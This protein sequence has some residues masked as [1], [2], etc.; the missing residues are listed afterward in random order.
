M[1]Q[2][3]L[4]NEIYRTNKI[5]ILQAL[6]CLINFMVT[7]INIMIKKTP[8]AQNGDAMNN[9]FTHYHLQQ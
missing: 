4:V 5:N 7:S 2:K 8:K 9:L 1:K 6:K 3:I